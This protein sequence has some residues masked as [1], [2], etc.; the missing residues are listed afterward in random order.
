MSSIKNKAKRTAEWIQGQAEQIHDVLSGDFDKRHGSS[1]SEI[2]KRLEEGETPSQIK[3]SI[4]RRN[5]LNPNV[6]VK[7]GHK[8]VLIKDRRGN[9]LPKTE[10]MSKGGVHF[11]G[12]F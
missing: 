4:L 11:K 9:R 7:G 6:L 1:I 8:N 12:T 10:G 2:K 3:K 5:P